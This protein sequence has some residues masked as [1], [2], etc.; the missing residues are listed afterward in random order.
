[1]WSFDL[2]TAMVTLSFILLLYMTMWD[3]LALKWNLLT[4]QTTMEISAF[5]A[6]ESLLTTPGNPKSWEMLP[7]IDENISAIGLVNGRNELNRMKLD[8]LVAENATAYGTVKARLGLQRYE[9]GMRITDL[10]ERETYYEFGIFSTGNLN[11]SLNFDRFGILDGTPVMV[12]L[13][14]WG[15]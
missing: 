6:A 10:S 3:S 2:L 9:F 11:N 15:K 7:H 5:F 4:R 14:V 12:H 1:M 8:K 13:E